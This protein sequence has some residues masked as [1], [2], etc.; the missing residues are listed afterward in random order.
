MILIISSTHIYEQCTEAVIEWLNYYNAQY[1]KMSLD[2]IY[3]GRRNLYIDVCKQNLIYDDNVDLCKDINVVFFRKKEFLDIKSNNRQLLNDLSKERLATVNYLFYILQHKKW[4]PYYSSNSENKLIQIKLAMKY[5][6]KVPGTI[7][8]NKKEDIMR[9]KKEYKDII[10]KP[11]NHCGYYEYNGDIYTANTIKFDKNKSVNLPEIFPLSLFQEQIKGDCELRCFYFDGEFYTIANFITCKEY[12]DIKLN[13]DNKTTN[14]S[15]Y[16]FPK[17]ERIKIIS[18][19]NE[20]KLNTGSID[21]ILKDSE[22]FF[23]EVNPVGQFLFESNILNLDL[24][25]KIAQWLIA[26]DVSS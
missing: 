1:Q 19:M 26:Q 2:D 20:L 8:T 22:L 16:D 15:I 9:F 4:F 3:K 17:K 18:M 14:Y 24:E 23:L 11:I 12:V 7:I 10:N 5:N 21:F 25:K 6:L 13:Q